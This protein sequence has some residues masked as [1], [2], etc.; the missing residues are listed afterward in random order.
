MKLIVA[1]PVALLVGLPLEIMINA[2]EK[3]VFFLIYWHRVLIRKFIPLEYRIH[4]RKEQE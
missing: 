4:F 2:L 1:V 3:L